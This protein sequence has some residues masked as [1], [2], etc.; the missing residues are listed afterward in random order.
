MLHKVEPHRADARADIVFVHGL[1]GDH[2][3][4]WM[5]DEDDD[6]SFWPA[7]LAKE[8]PDTNIWSLEYP[9][10]LSGWKGDGAEF[11][12]IVDSLRDFFGLGDL[13]ARPL[14]LVAHSLGGLVAKELL[15]TANQSNKTRDKRIVE[16]M[17]GIAFLATPHSGSG[18]ANFGTYVFSK[19]PGTRVQPVLQCLYANTAYLSRLGAWYRSNAPKLGVRTR[20][21]REGKRVGPFMVVNRTSSDPGMPDVD[22]TPITRN[23]FRICKPLTRKDQMYRGVSQFI[24]DCLETEAPSP[25]IGLLH[26]TGPATPALPPTTE[27]APPPLPPPQLPKPPKLFGRDDEL[28]ALVV[29]LMDGDEAPIAVLGQAG[30]GKSALTQA[31]LQ[32]SGVKA[33][34]GAR[35]WFVSLETANE[36]RAIWTSILLAL[37]EQPGPLPDGEALALLGTAPGLLVLDNGETPWQADAPGCEAAFAALANL[38][39]LK[40][41][42]SIRGQQAPYGPVWRRIPEAMEQLATDDARKLFLSLAGQGLAN[43]P[44]LEALLGELDGLPLAI[45]LIG[46]LAQG[47][48]GLASLLADYRARRTSLAVGEGKDSSLQASIRLSLDSP[49][50]EETARRLFAMMGRLPAGLAEEDAVALIDGG[51]AAARALRQIGIAWGDAQGRTRL[52]APIRQVAAA[53][54]LGDAD[55]EKLASHYFGLAA[56]EGG[57]VGAEG[58]REAIARLSPEIGNFEQLV[59]LAAGLEGDAPTAASGAAVSAASGLAELMRFTGLGSGET[60]AHLATNAKGSGDTLGEANCIQ[61]LGAVALARSDHAAARTAF[62]EAL[63]LYRE[64]GDTL[65]EA[66]C[67]KGLGD[68]ALARSDHAA[69]RTAYEQALPLYRRIGN[70]LGEA[71]C[72]FRLGVIALERS[73]HAAARTA[74]EAALPLYREIGDTLGEANCT[75]SLGDIAL[76]RSDHAAARTAFEA[77]LPLFR[78]IGNTLGEAN[79]IKSLGDIALARSDHAAARTAYELALPLYRRIGAILGEANCILSLG[80]IALDGGDQAAAGAQ[81]AAAL[82]LYQRRAEPFSIGQTHRRL[83]R[84]SEGAERTGQI[85]AAREAWT[86]IGR[87]DLVAELDEEFDGG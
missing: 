63:P 11:A 8:M 19:I 57:K 9:S 35:R 27:A 81:Y 5:H 26:P 39:E 16:M 25:P 49:R 60:L 34:F 76:A 66:N 33:H 84:I 21:Y 47:E 67:I 3:G 65:G 18:L 87:D 74:F 77:A 13:C 68:I 59:R 80:D 48:S 4:T 56:R 62:E 72:N 69:A 44:Q 73:D 6:E 1:G 17:R 53:L 2:R 7:W 12:D 70:T 86:S 41:V 46:H 75:F 54:A 30:I 52:L 43:D 55:R 15:Q 78:R 20:V 82:A 51:G 23:H 22:V 31:A 42:V 29:A 40:L 85:V 79:C 38:A 50:L 61:N 58:G 14:I 64:I 32:Q 71:N 37:G 83:A 45:R 36:A 10:A 24:K 28:A